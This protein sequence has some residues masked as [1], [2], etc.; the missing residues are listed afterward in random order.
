MLKVGQRIPDFSLQA[1]NGEVLTREDLHGS[2]AVVFFYPKS[3]TRGCTVE[4]REFARLAPEVEALGARIVGVSIDDADT[5]CRFAEDTGA[6]FPI[7]ADEDGKLAKGFGVRRLLLPIARRATFVIDEEGV[8]EEA[9]SM[10]LKFK[11]HAER[12]LNHLK[13]RKK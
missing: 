7:L 6:H 10:E 13:K 12:V 1:S 5:Q 8:V 2:P 9:F 11:E 3:F 4:T